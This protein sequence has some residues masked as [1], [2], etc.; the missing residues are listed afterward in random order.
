MVKHEQ[1]EDSWQVTSSA[2][3]IV[4]QCAGA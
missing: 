3:C 1:V 4:Q 2:E